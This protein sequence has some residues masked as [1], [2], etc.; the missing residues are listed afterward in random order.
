MHGVNKNCDPKIAATRPIPFAED[1]VIFELRDGR[2]G[3]MKL[4][5]DG[6]WAWSR[7]IGTPTSLCLANYWN[8][9]AS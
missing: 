2:L 5:E 7:I 3:E 8:A 6:D 4:N 9:M 1:S